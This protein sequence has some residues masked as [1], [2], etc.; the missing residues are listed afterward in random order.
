MAVAEAEGIASRV[1]LT[2]RRSREILKYYYASADVFVSTPW[3][4]PFGITPLEAMACGTPVVG[5]NV[6]GIKYTVL[7]G[8]TGY[9]VAPKDPEALAERLSALLTN[10]ERIKQFGQQSIQ[11]VN[12]HFT[13]EKVALDLAQV[14][15]ELSVKNQSPE[16]VQAWPIRLSEFESLTSVAENQNYMDQ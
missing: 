14:F 10:P 4:E 11:H 12:R 5:S 3:Y 15:E 7:N 16:L 9:L 2:G 1:V 6:G 8:E 13:W